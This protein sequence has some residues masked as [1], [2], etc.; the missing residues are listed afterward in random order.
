MEPSMIAVAKREKNPKRNYLLVN[1]F[2]GKH[3]PVSPTK[4]F[5]L[6]QELG[7]KLEGCYGNEKILMIGFAETATAIGAA[8][9]VQFDVSYIQTTREEIPGAKYLYFSEAHSHAA[10]Q[11]IVRNEFDQIQDQ[12]DRIIF[13]E[14]EITTGNTICNAIRVIEKEYEKTF[15]YSVISIV[16]GMDA[17]AKRRF[18]EKKIDRFYLLSAKNEVYQS[19]AELYRGDGS[20]HK[21]GFQVNEAYIRDVVLK[22]WTNPRHMT[23]GKAYEKACGELVQSI[24]RELD[25]C[26]KQK[27]LV[28]GT[29]EFMFPAMCVGAAL[30]QKGRSVKCH[31]TT[32]S[33]I[34]V[35]RE[36]EYPLKERWELISCYEES[37][38]TYVYELEAYDLVLV[39]TD[40][41]GVADRGMKTLLHALQECGNKDIIV[42]RWC[43]K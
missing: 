43:E 19:V 20:Y 26:Q 8:L 15:R 37:R 32:R 17:A 30:E 13:V 2:Q 31:A 6:F 12:I 41:P 21:A 42:V 9:A 24:C 22:G 35:S 29:E 14:D 40:A 34:A 10:E 1:R 39:I 27:I 38:K 11:K 16:N 28:L 7:Q 25:A 3:V 33:P 4:S 18:E 5:R 36:T 23:Q